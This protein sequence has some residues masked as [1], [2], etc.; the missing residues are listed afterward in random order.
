MYNEQQKKRFIEYKDDVVMPYNYL[1]KMFENSEKFETLYCKDLCN[2]NREEILDFYSWLSY[3]AL[4]TYRYLNSMAYNYT[5]WCF[6]NGFVIDGQNH[7]TEI[8]DEDLMECINR[9]AVEGSIISEEELESLLR[10]FENPRDQFLF[11]SLFEFGTSKEFQDIVNIKMSDLE[12]N[13]LHLKE[14]D[15]LVS[16]KWI[17]IARKADETLVFYPY[18]DK[19]RYD[20]TLVRSEYVYK[21]STRARGM[22]PNQVG[23]RISQ[24]YRALRNYLELPETMNP[25]SIINSGRIYWIKVNSARLGISPEDYCKQYK[26]VISNQFGVRFV[27]SNFVKEFRG[28]L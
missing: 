12:G 23:R 4:S 21:N 3:M 28:Y 5:Q 20:L 26:D 22:S 8:R 6:V 27:P 1:Q 2:F 11:Q 15:V 24:V 9:R 16:D 19:S 7:F 17:E 10:K 14:R 13:L 18:D 25:K